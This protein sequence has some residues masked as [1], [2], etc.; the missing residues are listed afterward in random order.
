MVL[1]K[2]KTTL[3]LFIFL[4][5]LTS[6]A[7][8]FENSYDVMARQALLDLVKT[9]KIYHNKHGN[10]TNQISE[11]LKLD[12]T[13]NNG[14]VYLEIHNADKNDYRAISLPAESTTARVFVYDTS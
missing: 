2:I 6:C 8:I 5:G 13:Y 14:R 3:L 7:T 1:F 10:Y 11:L 4:F 9:Q 12:L